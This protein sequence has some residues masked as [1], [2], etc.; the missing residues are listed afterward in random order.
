VVAQ[1]GGPCPASAT[2]E[3]LW[4]HGQSHHGVSRP[5][6]H[7]V[8]ACAGSGAGW[9]DVATSTTLPRKLR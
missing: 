1:V 4:R 9:V 3:R 5:Y 6:V 2:W 8:R 7:Q